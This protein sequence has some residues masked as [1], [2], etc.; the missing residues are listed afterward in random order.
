MSSR[1]RVVWR[2]GLFVKP[3]HFQ[4]EARHLAD[5]G[6]VAEL[7]PRQVQDLL[8]VVG[9]DILLRVQREPERELHQRQQ[10]E[11]PPHHRIVQSHP[12]QHRLSLRPV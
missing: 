8:E 7:R 3:Q 6:D 12:C 5:G 10:D 11:A 1:N 9:D 4:Q 2:E